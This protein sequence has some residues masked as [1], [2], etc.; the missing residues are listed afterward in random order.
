MTTN[1]VVSYIGFETIILDGSKT[2]FLKNI[3]LKE[4]VIKLNEVVLKSDTWSRQ[5]NLPFSKDSL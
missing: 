5:K 1:L 4:R 3:L 2:G